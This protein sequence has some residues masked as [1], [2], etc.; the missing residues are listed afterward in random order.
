MGTRPRLMTG[1]RNSGRL[2]GRDQEIKE[3]SK[4]VIIPP[5]TP[6]PPTNTGKN[7]ERDEWGRFGKNWFR[8]RHHQRNEA[9][10]L[11]TI[12]WMA[13]RSVNPPGCFS[14]NL[15]GIHLRRSAITHESAKSTRLR[16]L[17][18][19]KGLRQIQC[20]VHN[21]LGGMIATI[22]E[23]LTTLLVIG[24]TGEIIAKI[25]FCIHIQA[26]NKALNPSQYRSRVIWACS[27]GCSPS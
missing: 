9:Y 6:P 8:H 15:L 14:L 17:S 16:R 23:D 21:R 22:G 2:F 7:P 20:S 19:H 18:G 5:P 11:P 26:R 10:C 24:H 3:R 4:T 13:S 27:S 1:S 12:R 25:V